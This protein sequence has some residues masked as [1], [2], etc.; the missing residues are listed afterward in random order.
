MPAARIHEVIA[1]KVNQDCNY[2]NTL[3]RLGTISPD[4]WRNSE[5]LK[6]NN[7]KNITHFR[8]PDVTEGE[9][10]DYDRFYD[11]Y[12]N[13]I[14]N[15]FYFG[16]L[17]HLMVDQYWKT[18][19][20]PKYCFKENGID[21]CRLR[22]GSIVN[23]EHYFSYYEDEKIQRMLAKKYNLGLLPT[24]MD[25]LS[26]FECNIE[27]IDLDGL[28][29]PAGTVNFVN[30]RLMPKEKSEESVLYGFNDIDSYT[31]ETTEFVKQ[32]LTRLLSLDNESHRVQ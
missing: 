6:N 24:N 19:I 5:K 13:D 17:V 27:E 29:G 1:L 21:K 3:L 20:D 7:G 4:S 12:K 15:P 2:D 31:D 30:S 14:N 9:S 23:N 25:E 10:N 16:Y 32:E 8:N 26:N 22:D 18:Y 28:F 11:K